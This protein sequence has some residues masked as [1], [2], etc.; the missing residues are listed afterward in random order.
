MDVI[1]G[2]FH[3]FSDITFS[4]QSSLATLISLDTLQGWL[5]LCVFARVV[6]AM[7]CGDLV[8]ILLVI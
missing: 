5:S 1:S 2:D 8:S 3:D 6:S 7:L 4:I